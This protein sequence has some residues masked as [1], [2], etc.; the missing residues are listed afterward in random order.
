MESRRLRKGNVIWC[1]KMFII[2]DDENDS[3]SAP[4]YSFDNNGIDDTETTYFELERYEFYCKEIRGERAII[5]D[6]FIDYYRQ[7][8]SLSEVIQLP[9]FNII[10]NQYN[11]LF[12]NEYKYVEF[13]SGI[14]EFNFR[15]NDK[16]PVN[17]E[18]APKEIVG[19]DTVQMS[20]NSE[21]T[22]VSGQLYD[23]SKYEIIATL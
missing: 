13:V 5:Y 2:I 19:K 3:N 18:I 7:G 11:D 9:I 4:A 21:I 16:L 10:K 23:G 20:Y 8:M 22:L 6:S 17:I 1:G 15:E 12:P 14:K